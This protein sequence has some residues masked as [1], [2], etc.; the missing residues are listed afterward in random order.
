MKVLNIK[1]GKDANKATIA[2]QIG[3]AIAGSDNTATGDNAPA[4]VE[5]LDRDAL[6]KF[7]ETDEEY[8]AFSSEAGARINALVDLFKENEGKYGCSIV[9]GATLAQGK[10]SRAGGCAISGTTSGI[11]HALCGLAGSDI[12]K[13]FH[14]VAIKS[15]TE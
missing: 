8:K 6:R 5:E 2:R 7:A 4:K 9:V 1:I 10:S 15:L 13:I 12:R 11:A 3:D 14:K